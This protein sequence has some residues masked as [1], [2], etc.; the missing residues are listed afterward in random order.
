M[1]R[2]RCRAAGLY[3][4]R[5]LE[6]RMPGYVLRLAETESDLIEFRRYIASA[7]RH[8][9][10]LTGDSPLLDLAG[11][12]D[13]IRGPVLPDL[14]HLDTVRLFV[15]DIDERRSWAM[16]QRVEIDLAR[17][18]ASDVVPQLRLL[19]DEHPFEERMWALLMRALYHS[20]RQTD[21]LRAY[22]ELRANLV[23]QLGVEPSPALKAIE[24]GILEGTLG[25][26]QYVSSL[27]H[28]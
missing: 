21:A 12:L 13:L 26:D 24:R 11:A 7:Q 18:R 4:R 27:L 19:V 23:E 22:Q 10:A 15:A 20:G 2:K 14:D 25:R 3:D 1:L 9:A 5:I 6:T 8:L 17:G 16:E 28:R